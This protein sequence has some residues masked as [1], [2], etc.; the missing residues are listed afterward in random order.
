MKRMHLC[1]GERPIIEQGTH[2]E[3]VAMNGYYADMER[4]QRLEEELELAE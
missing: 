1:A 3:L 2:D 4:R